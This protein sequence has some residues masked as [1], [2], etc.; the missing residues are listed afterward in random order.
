[1]HYTAAHVPTFH[2]FWCQYTVE[3]RR[4]DNLKRHAQLQH[5]LQLAN[6]MEEFPTFKA[7]YKNRFPELFPRDTRKSSVHQAPTAL[8]HPKPLSP[9]LSLP[10]TPIVTPVTDTISLDEEI[11]KFMEMGSLKFRSGDKQCLPSPIYTEHPHHS[12]VVT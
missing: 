8:I 5:S 11:S 6:L 1:M 10:M 4:F 2:C 3:S 12:H 7:A 9:R